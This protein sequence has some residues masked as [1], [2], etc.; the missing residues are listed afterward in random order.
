MAA[1]SD[2]SPDDDSPFWSDPTPVSPGRVHSRVF[3]IGVVTIAVT[4]LGLA[5]LT[6]AGQ[7]DDAERTSGAG[8]KPTLGACTF[9]VD[10]KTTA[11]E[12]RKARTLTMVAA[13]GQQIAAPDIQ[14]AHALDVATAAPSAAST[15]VMDALALL[16]AEDTLGA[17]ES[18]LAQLRALGTPGALSCLYPALPLTKEKVADSGLTRRSEKVKEAVLDAFG[19]VPTAGYSDS[20]KKASTER[21]LK[22]GRAFDVKFTPVDD[23]ARTRG[24]VLAHWLAARGATLNIDRVVYDE[25]VWK[26]TS[27]A[28]WQVLP[29][30]ETTRRL[31]RVHLTVLRGN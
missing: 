6:W 13:V 16:A 19:K 10:G 11:L 4:V 26:A 18:G 31:D 12:A 24:W 29:T 23:A 27:A 2:P 7:S 28:G 14:I 5:G 1:F 25:H 22:E 20:T 21:A 30:T 15:K 3:G 9:T 8:L 17:S